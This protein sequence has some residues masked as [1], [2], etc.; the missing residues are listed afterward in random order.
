MDLQQ[1]WKGFLVGYSCILSVSL[2]LSLVS[3]GQSWSSLFLPLV[4]IVLLSI[5]LSIPAYFNF[6]VWTSCISFFVVVATF[7]V[8]RFLLY[9][10]ALGHAIG[11]VF[12]TWSLFLGF[13]VGAFLEALVY[14]GRHVQKRQPNLPYMGRRKK[15]KKR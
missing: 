13:F 6:K 2:I 5:I 15:R 7:S 8:L 4:G 9:N 11:I 10:D 12:F 3:Q 14:L 1:H